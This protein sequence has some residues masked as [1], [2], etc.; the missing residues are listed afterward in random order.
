MSN[1]HE[2]AETAR[3]RL[4]EMTGSSSSL[5]RDA[6]G[7]QADFF[8][9]LRLPEITPL[10]KQRSDSISEAIFDHIKG[11]EAKLGDDEELFIYYS[12]L[13]EYIAVEKVGFPTWETICLYG[14]DSAGR[15]N[16]IVGAIR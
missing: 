12:S 1:L 8:A 6:I 13:R 9:K 16:S 3:K 7:P 11:L 5:L 4:D 14:F 15:H 2:I 10:A